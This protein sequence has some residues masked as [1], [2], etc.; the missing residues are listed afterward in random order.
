LVLVVPLAAQSA[1]RSPHKQ[2]FVSVAPGVQLEVLEWPSAAEPLVFLVGAGS[3][4]HIY[5]N[6]ASRF[7][8]RFHV[9]AIT[10]RGQGAS[11]RPAVKADVPR[12][13][14]DIV[15]VVDSLGIGR[16]IFAGH[17]FA[18]DEL[19]RLAGDFPA[20]VKSLVY[21][22]AAYDRPAKRKLDSSLGL[23]VPAAPPMPAE[24]SKSPSA[25]AAQIRL[26]I[27][28]DFPDAEIRRRFDF[29]DDGKPIVLKKDWRGESYVAEPPDY[30]RVQAPALGVYAVRRSAADVFPYY[31]AQDSAFRLQA[32]R[33]FEAETSK[34][35]PAEREKFRR[36][37][38]HSCVIGIPGASHYVFLSNP[39]D[40][41]R[42]MR[43]F[44]DGTCP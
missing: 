15:A 16:A 28:A 38:A 41:E 4:A 36:G 20:R 1:D 42:A 40:T 29:A 21:L 22:D 44:F 27:G 14:A 17:S 24:A 18:G 39:D 25:F 23:Q 33:F 30:S 32:D 6:F 3:S 35:D 13:V 12:L 8:D 43:A 9:Y 34:Y 5:D 7:T 11:S 31:H 26:M 37:V 19:T 2:H 10:R